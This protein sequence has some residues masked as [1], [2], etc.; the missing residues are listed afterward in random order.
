MHRTFSFQHPLRYLTVVALSE[1]ST[2]AR[3]VLRFVIQTYYAS[4]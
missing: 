3:S 4:V 2:A 1:R